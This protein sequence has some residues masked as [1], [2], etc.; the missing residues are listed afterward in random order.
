MKE[1][2]G[3][4]FEEIYISEDKTI[5]VFILRAPFL[6]TFTYIATGDCCSESWFESVLNPENITSGENIVS[7]I[8]IKE[9][10][11]CC[12]D[13]CDACKDLDRWG[14]CY[15]S[16]YGYTLET[17]LGYCDIEYRNASNGCYDGECEY[18]PEAELIRKK[19]EAFLKFRPDSEDLIKLNKIA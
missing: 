10:T 4:S 1:L 2:L 7:G 18:I 15:I 19:S 6:R 12:N 13:S 11:S 14:N 17:I 9:Q 3:K 16:V 5:L 8:K